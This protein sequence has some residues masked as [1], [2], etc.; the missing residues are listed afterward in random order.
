MPYIRPPGGDANSLLELSCPTTAAG[1]RTL[2]QSTGHHH[3]HLQPHWI[4]PQPPG[5]TGLKA[6]KSST[7]EHPKAR[8]CFLTVTSQTPSAFG[9]LLGLF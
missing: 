4:Q 5:E 9:N 7:Q 3:I 1:C 8:P 6:P 2:G